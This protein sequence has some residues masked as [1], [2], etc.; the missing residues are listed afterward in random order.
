MPNAARFAIRTKR[1]RVWDPLTITLAIAVA[2]IGIAILL[3]PK[4]ESP[5]RSDHSVEKQVPSYMAQAT[6]R[7]ITTDR[8]SPLA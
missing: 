6:P 5:S 7:V 1:P 8:S 3:M 2:L 4:P